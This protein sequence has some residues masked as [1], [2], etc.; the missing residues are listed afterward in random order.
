MAN[1]AA[2]TI[3]LRMR[4]EA[5]A[6]MQQFG[7]T[8]QEARLQSIEFNAA[9]TAMGSAL[10]AVGSLL[11]QIDNPAAKAAATFIT[12][13]G[14]IL[15]TTSA[16]IQ[17]IPYIR[18]LITWLRSLAVAQA[19]IQALSGPAG[20]ATLGIGVAVAGAATAGIIAATGGFGNRGGTTVNVNTSAFMGSDADA[21]KFATKTQRYSRENERLGR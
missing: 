9:L 13:A 17:V 21:R 16:I 5:S 1:E 7:N 3:V 2:T 10:T 18:Q 8:T 15:A 12:T 6:G 4:D 14:A 20:W 11:N 19:I